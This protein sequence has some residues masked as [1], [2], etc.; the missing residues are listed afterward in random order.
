MS[1]ALNLTALP[2]LGIITAILIYGSIA[3]LIRFIADVKKV[4]IKTG[5]IPSAIRFLLFFLAL[6]ALT[7]ISFLTLIW[8]EN[9]SNGKIIGYYVGLVPSLIFLGFL[10]FVILKFEHQDQKKE[11]SSQ[12]KGNNDKF[13]TLNLR[14]ISRSTFILIQVFV[15]FVT[16]V[17]S[18]YG[19]V[20]YIGI[21]IIVVSVL[22][23]IGRL[24][25]LNK[26]GWNILLAIP[27]YLYDLFAVRGTLG[28]NEYGPDPKYS[29]REAN[30]IKQ[31]EERIEKNNLN[32]EFENIEDGEFYYER[33]SIKNLI[34][35]SK[36]FFAPNLFQIVGS[37]GN[38]Y[39]SYFLTTIPLILVISSIIISITM[40]DWH[41]LLSIP[42][43][44][45][46]L[47]TNSPFSILGTI[48][49][50]TMA[51]ILSYAI[52]N[53]EF[54]IALAVTIGI[55]SYLSFIL[56]RLLVIEILFRRAYYSKSIFLLLKKYN[57]LR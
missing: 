15:V 16:S 42:L 4:I 1:T 53:K 48:F 32:L 34:R 19:L 50:W 7:F 18:I 29:K 5:N 22:S 55:L 40:R 6:V 10:G 54:M 47:F 46:G 13:T 3:N 17:F 33:E 8:L 14:R 49:V 31:A 25:D 20:D 26:S 11:L 23:I 45:L 27:L 43:V 36:F 21:L 2:I 52:G 39:F 44:V 57:F 28:S 12:K 41:V 51:L 24:H 9:L 37:K 56:Q 38:I 30:A 35:S